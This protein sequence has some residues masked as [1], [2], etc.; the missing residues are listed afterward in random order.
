MNQQP[1]QHIFTL[2]AQVNLN[3]VNA[4]RQ[5]GP[6]SHIESERRIQN[7]WHRDFSSSVDLKHL[8]T[9][10]IYDTLHSVAI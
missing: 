3:Q 8:A 9:T 6:A 7:T 4:P 10:E 1:T 2:V 5:S